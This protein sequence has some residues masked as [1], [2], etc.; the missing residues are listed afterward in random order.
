MVPPDFDNLGG[1]PDHPRHRSST[2]CCAATNT[3]T[4]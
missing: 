3:P 2:V 4:P 1:T